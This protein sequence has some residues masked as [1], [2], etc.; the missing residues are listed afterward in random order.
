MKSESAQFA[1][2]RLKSAG[3][4]PVFL[5]DFNLAT[6]IYLSTKLMHKAPA[7]GGAT[8]LPLILDFDEIYFALEQGQNFGTLGSCAVI[9]ARQTA[10][11]PLLGGGVVGIPVAVDLVFDKDTDVQSADLMPMARFVVG[12]ITNINQGAFTVELVADERLLVTLPKT[13]FADVNV[14]PENNKRARVPLALG[15]FTFDGAAD[16]R[17]F[18][19]RDKNYLPNLLANELYNNPVTYGSFSRTDIGEHIVAE[20]S[21]ATTGNR[22]YQYIDSW[23]TLALVATN[24]N[25]PSLSPTNTFGYTNSTG[26]IFSPSSTVMKFRS[27]TDRLISR[28]V[29]CEVPGN[30]INDAASGSKFTWRNCSDDDGANVTRME[31]GLSPAR[32]ILMLG[33][34]RKGTPATNRPTVGWLSFY[35]TGADTT[36]G[37]G[38]RLSVQTAR[39]SDGILS[40][41]V[42]INMGS[43]IT[44]PYIVTIGQYNSG[45][46][47]GS[48]TFGGVGWDWDTVF[49]KIAIS[50]I[51]SSSTQWAEIG[52]IGIELLYTDDNAAFKKTTATK[53]VRGTLIRTKSGDLQV[54]DLPPFMGHFFPKVSAIRPTKTEFV[55]QSD[56]VM[57]ADVHSVYT[58]STAFSFTN[59]SGPYCLYA[60]LRDVL[61]YGEAGLDGITFEHTDNAQQNAVT[62]TTLGVYLDKETAATEFLRNVAFNSHCLLFRSGDGK[63]KCAPKLRWITYAGFSAPITQFSDAAGDYIITGLTWRI[64]PPVYNKFKINYGYDYARGRYVLSSENDQSGTIP[65]GRPMEEI[66]LPYIRRDFLGASHWLPEFVRFYNV[67]RRV[68]SFT[69]SLAATP[70][71]LGDYIKVNHKALPDNTPVYQIMEIAYGKLTVRI[72]AIEI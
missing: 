12:G 66:E 39:I 8:Y 57:F 60:I 3:M 68:V 43:G 28:I 62:V 36:T 19:S 61:G 22:F 6:P 41:V 34:N 17:L 10:T 46:T 70:L 58:L 31:L 67:N 23:D 25:S 42:Q 65:N 55:A 37:G 18:R 11:V 40:G 64:L 2:D 1:I 24:A 9:I 32:D 47:I 26:D 44:F 53:L 69:T 13:K 14:V 5:W 63:W 56:R 71:E 15:D 33:W 38:T 48:G 45:S 59:Y 52:A 29:E 51:T 20:A 27:T 49:L 50:G 4:K 7:S 16:H 72:T 21:A 30:L 35:I 54:V